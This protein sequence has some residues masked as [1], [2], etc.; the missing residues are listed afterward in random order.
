MVSLS[1]VKDTHAEALAGCLR[2]LCSGSSS[3]RRQ[4]ERRFPVQN[5]PRS[6]TH[7]SGDG[8]LALHPA[9]S[10]ALVAFAER[11]VLGVSVKVS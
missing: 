4:L 10:T 2:P 3:S 8:T 6:R 9:L 11:F 5:S 7:A 1:P